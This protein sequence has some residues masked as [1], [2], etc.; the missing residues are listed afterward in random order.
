MIE[1]KYIVVRAK[2]P[3]KRKIERFETKYMGG[4]SKVELRDFIDKYKLRE[5]LSARLIPYLIDDST[6]GLTMR[7]LLPSGVSEDI[8]Q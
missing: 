7:T 3:R 5:I 6:P 8:L 2:A 1:Q 4:D